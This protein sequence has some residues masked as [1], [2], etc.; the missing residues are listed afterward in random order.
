MIQP[1]SPYTPY[2]DVNQMLG[3][4]IENIQGVLGDALYAMYLEGSLANGDFDEDSDIDFV[5]VT[6]GEISEATFLALR[7]MHDRLQTVDSIWADQ[8]EGSYLSKWGVRRY[9]P[10]FALY[11]NMERG[12]GERLKLWH[13]DEMW[14]IHR[15]ILVKC[16]I[17]IL[18]PEPKA[19]I[20]PV[21]VES[22]RK[23]MHVILDGWATGF[24][25]NPGL[26][27]TRGYQSYV[28][29]SMCRI[30][31]TLE[32]GDIISKKAAARWASE[33]LEERWQ[34]LI[35]SAWVGR[36]RSNMPPYEEDVLG[37][38]AMI[39]YVMGEAEKQKSSSA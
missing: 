36:H 39:R 34:P 9:D 37:T 21:A 30:L 15:H 26:M 29:L 35:E 31:Y 2:P 32:H 38:L 16:G 1:E 33:T 8:L 18:G 27:A 7:E 11:P 24:L 4:L 23:A 3:I 28:V 19:L 6:E 13:H 25:T 17:P 5:V 20:D 14:D 22:L 12:R 10:A